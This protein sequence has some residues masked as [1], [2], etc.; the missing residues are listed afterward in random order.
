[1]TGRNTRFGEWT[2]IE[3]ETF[4]SVLG[5]FASGVTIVTGVNDDRP[6]GLVCQSFFSLSLHP[7]LIAIAPSTTSTSW[8]AIAASGAFCINVLTDEQEP[9]CRVFARS[10]GDK[11]AGVGWTPASSGSPRLDGVL[12]W[13]DCRVEAVHQAGD[14]WLV[15]G[16][17][18]DLGIG[19]GEPLL[20]YRGGFGTFTA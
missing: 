16:A 13:V 11:F 9:L 6:A 12:A 1:M 4:R 3:Q 2:A 7:P 18:E 10:G 15:V 20:F 8:P 14:H 17:V 5:H 19:H